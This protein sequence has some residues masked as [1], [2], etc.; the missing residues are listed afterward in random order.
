MNSLQCNVSRKELTAALR[1]ADVFL[2]KVDSYDKHE[3][4][5]LTGVAVLDIKEEPTYY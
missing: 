4:K 2:S 5:A 1:L 3:P